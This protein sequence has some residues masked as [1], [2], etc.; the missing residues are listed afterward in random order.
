MKRSL[1]R[2]TGTAADAKRRMTLFKLIAGAA[3]VVAGSTDAFS[4][5]K[6]MRTAAMFS[7]VLAHCSCRMDFCS[8]KCRERWRWQR[9]LP[10]V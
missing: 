10:R 1:F 3:A 7:D 6:D 8:A 9:Q 2:S 4:T 5:T